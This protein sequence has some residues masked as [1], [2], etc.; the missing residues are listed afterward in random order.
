MP[1]GAVDRE[2]ERTG[3]V[4][5]LPDRSLRESAIHDTQSVL[6]GGWDRALA[7]GRSMSL[8]E[9]LVYAAALVSGG[10]DAPAVARD[11][12]GGSISPS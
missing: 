11:T 2:R 8:D 9:A 1:V 3:L 4:V 6:E 12:V 5:R 7:E 10:G